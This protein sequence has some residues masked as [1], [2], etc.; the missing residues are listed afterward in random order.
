MPSARTPA[1]GNMRSKWKTV[2]A[3]YI[4]TEKEP[5]NIDSRKGTYLIDKRHLVLTDHVKVSKPTEAAGAALGAARVRR[6]RQD[7]GQSGQGHNP[8]SRR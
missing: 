6:C 5:I 8:V 3:M 7:A 2:S 4:G 1:T